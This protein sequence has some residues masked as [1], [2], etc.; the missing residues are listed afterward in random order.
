MIMEPA[1]LSGLKQE[2]EG[3]RYKYPG[4]E[5]GKCIKRLYWES[6]ISNQVIECCTSDALSKE[7]IK[8][9]C[10]SMTVIWAAMDEDILPELFTCSWSN[11]GSKIKCLRINIDCV[12][13]KFIFMYNIKSV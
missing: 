1:K 2:T 13:Q 11:S 12:V 4:P 6:I 5:Y 7:D 10:W 3:Q 9:W 8:V